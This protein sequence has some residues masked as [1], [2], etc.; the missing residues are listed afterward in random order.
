VSG[1]GASG[2]AAG[3]RVVIDSPGHPWTGHE[4][5]IDS[6]AHAADLGWDWWVSLAG[7]PGCAT[8]AADSDLRPRTREPEAGQ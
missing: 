3:D 2:R 5:C 4:G 6:Q 1:L 8:T 7:Y